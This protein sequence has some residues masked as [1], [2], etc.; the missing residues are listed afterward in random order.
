MR[1]G[2]NHGLPRVLHRRWVVSIENDLI[3]SVS[4]TADGVPEQ[5]RQCPIIETSATIYPPFPFHNC[6]PSSLGSV[7]RGIELPGKTGW[8]SK[9]RQLFL[10][11][12]FG[13]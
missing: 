12:F 2:R 13:L 3:A 5:L 6:P 11:R 4:A 8:G 10:L 1:S 9:E 7:R